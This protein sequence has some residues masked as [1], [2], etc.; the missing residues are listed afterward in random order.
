MSIFRE[1]REGQVA[2]LFGRAL[3]SGFAQIEWSVELG[4]GTTSAAEIFPGLE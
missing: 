2:V 1:S 3:A 4:P